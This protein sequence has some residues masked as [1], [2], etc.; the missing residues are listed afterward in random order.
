MHVCV[1]V[2]ER[3]R[4]RERESV[5]ACV[6]MHVYV[7][8][9]MYVESISLYMRQQINIIQLKVPL[10]LLTYIHKLH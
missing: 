7:C 5:C 9:C 3:E 1:C 6:C 2:R 8:E 10:L 4:E